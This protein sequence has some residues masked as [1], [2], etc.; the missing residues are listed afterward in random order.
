LAPSLAII[1]FCCLDWNSNFDIRLHGQFYWLTKSPVL[2]SVHCLHL[3]YQEK[4][5]H[6]CKEV[7]CQLNRKVSELCK[8]IRIVIPICQVLQ[9]QLYLQIQRRKLKF[10]YEKRSLRGHYL[11]KCWK[12]NPDTYYL[13]FWIL[14]KNFL[15]K[16]IAWVSKMGKIS[17]QEL[18]ILYKLQ[19]F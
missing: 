17:S 12:K 14:S 16:L 18:Q 3:K 15:G 4:I 6:I 13:I 1:A 9:K 2:L 11:F 7:A 8:K 10:W 5:S 19:W